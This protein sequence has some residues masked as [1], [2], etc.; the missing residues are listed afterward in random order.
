[1]QASITLRLLGKLK[2]ELTIAHILPV[3]G[4]GDQGL[5]GPAAER[6]GLHIGVHALAEDGRAVAVILKLVVL[7]HQLA[8]E[9][10]VVI[11]RAHRFPVTPVGCNDADLAAGI[12]R[13]FLH[14]HHAAGHIHGVDKR[15]IIHRNPPSCTF[16]LY[17]IAR[18]FSIVRL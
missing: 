17:R 4:Q 5:V 18:L 16:L 14:G 8:V 2:D 3:R 10:T 13:R 6:L 7:R 15:L 9:H 1:M 12:L 11:G